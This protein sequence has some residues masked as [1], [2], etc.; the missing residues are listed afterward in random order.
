M[1]RRISTRR[2]YPQPRCEVDDQRCRERDAR[3]HR[4]E[5]TDHGRWCHTAALV[6]VAPCR[7]PPLSSARGQQGPPATSP[8]RHRFRNSDRRRVPKLAHDV[9]MP[10]L[11]V[12]A[13]RRGSC[14]RRA[15]APRPARTGPCATP[16]PGY[17]AAAV[18]AETSSHRA[19]RDRHHRRG[20]GRRRRVRRGGRGAPAGTVAALRLAHRGDR[21][22][23]TSATRPS[24]ADRHAAQSSRRARRLATRSPTATTPRSTSRAMSTRSRSKGSPPPTFLYE[25]GSG[26]VVPRLDEELRGKRAGDIPEKFRR[27][28]ARAVRRRAARGRASRFWVKEAKR[29]CCPT[30]PTSGCRRSASSTR[31]DALRGDVR[32]RLDLYGARAGVDGG[33]REDLRRRR[34]AR[35]RR[36]ARDAR[37]PGDGAAAPRSRPPAREQGS[38]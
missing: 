28:P 9:K 33:A 11:P 36:S 19:A 25:V 16:L 18:E 27:H 21:T 13:R 7:S 10:G 17:Y 14:W 5:V 6:G 2:R 15:S 38:G 4:I 3:H 12:P 22:R 34:G 8:C 35:R 1:P 26:I 23:P 30:S 29:K 24:T 37:E 32:T 31:V 20:G